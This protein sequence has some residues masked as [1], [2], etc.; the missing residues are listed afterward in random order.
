MSDRWLSYASRRPTTALSGSGAGG[1]FAGGVVSPGSAA[2]TTTGVGGISGA[3]VFQASVS[4]SVTG[5][6]VFCRPVVC[7]A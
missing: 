2:G 7:L 1:G 3:L 4:R 6:G 5:A